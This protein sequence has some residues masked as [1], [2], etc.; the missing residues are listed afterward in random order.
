MGDKMIIC[1][2]CKHQ[3]TDADDPAIPKGQCPA[4][5]IYYFKY[6]NQK[7]GEPR[8]IAPTPSA[9]KPPQ[10][11][12]PSPPTKIEQPKPLPTEAQALLH[13][14]ELA[15]HKTN[16]VLHLLLSLITLGWWVIVWMIAY[17]STTSTRNEIHRKYGFP[18][19]SN[20]LGIVLTVIVL[21][22]SF[23]LSKSCTHS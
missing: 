15:Q 1:P 23:S 19:E 12:A 9:T 17:A 7:S 22:I 2:K 4:C 18:T 10:E 5:G 11:P 21:F 13:L 3:R 20:A 8:A 14:T 16:H 6:L